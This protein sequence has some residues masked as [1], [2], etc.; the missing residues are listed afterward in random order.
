[1][2][3]VFDDRVKLV[4]IGCQ[5]CM[6]CRRKKSKEWQVRM[7]EDIKTNKNGKMVT[8]TFSN[9][10]ITKI[11][12]EGKTKEKRDRNIVIP[13]TPLKELQGYE[14]DNAI[15]AYAIRKFLERWRKKFKK[16]LRHWLVTE[17]G[18]NGT[19]NIHLH[20]IVWTDENYS[21]IREKW[22]Y[23]FIYP[24][25]EE[26]EQ[27]GYVNAR[28]V[29]YIVKYI[30]KI[31]RDH[32]GFK[33]TILTSAGIGKN[34]TQTRQAEG[35]LYKPGQTVESYTNTQGFK[36]SLPIYWRNK[37]YTDEE[38]EKLWIEKLNKNERWINGIRIDISKN[39]DY[40]YKVLEQERMKNIVL[41]FG[42]NQTDWDKEE[43]EK[44]RR[45]LMYEQRTKK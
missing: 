41:G 33:S 2:P 21:T 38:R 34:Y 24:R 37:I 23:G 7:L 9:E 36:Y 11:I 31:D 17:L 12:E 16:S 4:P 10:S 32:E 22:A 20:G 6:E 1:V 25:T 42:T 39:E 28:T 14:L 8:L 35:N 13:G 27:K 40:Y 44:Q 19:E 18:H 43:Y 26:Q 45:I 3:A 29:N 15:A 30:T 5:Q